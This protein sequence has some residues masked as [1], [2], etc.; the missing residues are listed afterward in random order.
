[1][2]ALELTANELFDINDKDMHS[3]NLK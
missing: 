3:S 2:S 1:M